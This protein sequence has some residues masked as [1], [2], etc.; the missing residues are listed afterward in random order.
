MQKAGSKCYE[1]PFKLNLSEND[2]QPEQV[3]NPQRVYEPL[4]K[5]RTKQN[6]TPT[7]FLLYTHG[8]YISIL[9][10]AT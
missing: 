7:H 3:I 6:I 2:L 1:L 9:K 8:V 10:V 4:F 5:M